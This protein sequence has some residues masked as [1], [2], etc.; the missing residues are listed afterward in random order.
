MTS[1]TNRGPSARKKSLVEALSCI[2]G[3]LIFALFI[4]RESIF[5]YVAYLG[6]LLAAYAVSRSIH[7]IASMKSVLGFVPISRKVLI[8]T[9][10]GLVLGA[11][12]AILNNYSR[13][14]S[15]FPSVLTGFA[16]IAPVIGI[17]EELVFRGYVQT[18]LAHTGTVLAILIA[19]AGHTIYK[20]IVIRTLP[21]EIA[22]NFTWLIVLTFIVGIVFGFIRDRS[23][24]I[25]PAAMAHAI[26]DIIIYGGLV[27]APFW[28]WG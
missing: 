14:D 3:I 19:S 8:Y 2:F 24:S 23:G 26:F 13:G 5:Q 18:K 10:V 12:L 28:V 25:Y 9:M 4:Q 6:L 1:Y 22:V 7:D 15:L 20:F 16:L 17:M 11:L 21:G 27:G